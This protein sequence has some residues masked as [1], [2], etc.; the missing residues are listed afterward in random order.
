MC[1]TWPENK[2]IV[3]KEVFINTYFKNKTNFLDFK[4]QKK[5]ETFITIQEVRVVHG[6][7]SSLLI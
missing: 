6:S 1:H 5:M 2:T 4:Y 3:L 7:Y